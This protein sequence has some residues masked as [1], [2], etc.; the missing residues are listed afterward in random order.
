VWL[1]APGGCRAGTHPGVGSP[2]AHWTLLTIPAAPGLVPEPPCQVPQE[3]ACHAGQ[4][5]CLAAQVL[6][7]GGRHRAARGSPAY[8][9]ESRLSLL[10]IVVPLQ[11]RAGTPLDWKGQLGSPGCLDS[12]GVLI[13]A[14]MVSKCPWTRD[15]PSS[16]W[17][18]VPACECV[19]EHGLHAWVCGEER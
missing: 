12:S 2:A 11:V 14:W 5:L 4:P 6:Q 9:P 17:V 3:R 15:P 1:P 8:H 13:R 10:A 7:P 16:V 18:S 19:H